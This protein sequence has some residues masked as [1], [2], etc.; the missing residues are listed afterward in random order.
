MN[1]LANSIFQVAEE[2]LMDTSM[3]CNVTD[4]TLDT[5]QPCTNTVPSTSVVRA[6]QHFCFIC[7]DFHFKI[8]RHFETH[9]KENSDI[10]YALSLP[11]RSATRKKLLENLRNRGN[12]K[13]NRDVLKKGSAQLKVKRRAKKNVNIVSIVWVCF[14]DQNYGDM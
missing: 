3:N 14:C 2:S 11:A 10:A 8:A 5:G 9:I 7:K 13:Y 4:E 6:G 12:F 1:S